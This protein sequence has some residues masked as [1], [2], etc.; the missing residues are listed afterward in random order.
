[1]LND[2]IRRIQRIAFRVTS[3]D[4][5]HYRTLCGLRDYMV[6]SRVLQSLI[7][8]E[9]FAEGVDFRRLREGVLVLVRFALSSALRMALSAGDWWHLG[10]WP[11]DT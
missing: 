5:L 9:R 4:V 11:S 3:A 2:L 6:K 7:L 8:T 10:D 1:M